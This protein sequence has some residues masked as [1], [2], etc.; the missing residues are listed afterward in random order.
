MKT[1]V[2]ILLLITLIMVPFPVIASAELIKPNYTY[3]SAIGSSLSIDNGYATCSG[4]IKLFQAYDSVVTITLQRSDGSG[5]TNIK[6]W[7][8]SFSSIGLNSIEKEYYVSAGYTY[9]V[10]TIGEV[11]D[12]ST[13]LETATSYSPERSY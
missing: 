12:N 5:W 9:R 6:T 13:V 2:T 4:Y 11:M 10:L 8:Q 1:K 7:S 3:I